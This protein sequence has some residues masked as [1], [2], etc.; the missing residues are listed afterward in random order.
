[1]EEENLRFKI[2]TSREN[3]CLAKVQA[4][5]PVE[6]VSMKMED[7]Y[8]KIQG[9]A[10]LSGFRRGHAPIDLIR[11]NFEKECRQKVADVL[12]REIVDSAVEKEKLDDFFRIEVE[13]FD[14]PQTGPVT[15]KLNVHIQPQPEIKP[16]RGLKIEI[17]EKRVTDKEI[18]EEIERMRDNYA[19]LSPSSDNV[20]HEDSFAVIDYQGFDGNNKIEKL[21]GQNQ[22]TGARNSI[23]QGKLAGL[24]KG[25]TVKMDY[26][27]PDSFPD[28]TYAGKPCQL[29]VT[30]KEVKK[31]ILPELDDEFA[32]NFNVSTVANLRNRVRQALISAAEITRK[33]E[34]GEKAVEILVGNNDF[35][36][37]DYL[38]QIELDSMIQEV[39]NANQIPDEKTEES[40]RRNWRP[41]A[42]KRA[43][44]MILLNK[45]AHQE[46]LDASKE[47]IEEE[48]KSYRKI[49]GEP[50]TEVRRLFK[51]REDL[52]RNRIARRKALDF[53]V[54]NAKISAKQKISV[55]RGV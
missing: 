15:M 52:F 48:M 10:I 37:S 6:A 43:R 1:V 8:A 17:E 50:E 34:I 4:E 46:K 55:S 23:F 29:E 21:S 20:V 49:T 53:L 30:V 45:I 13:Q 25:D 22:I 12:L 27:V 36:I 19:Q 18:D 54:E 9:T 16:Y 26:R 35:P 11:Q 31:R 38:V 2:N 40:F 14:F 51:E 42:E 44:A 28:K 3:P 5:I 24:K 41:Q 39:K 32:H 7:A 47:D 33:R